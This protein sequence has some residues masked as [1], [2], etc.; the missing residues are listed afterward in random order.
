[1]FGNNPEIKNIA[2]VVIAFVI[3][4]IVAS[5]GDKT[6]EGELI[7]INA[8]EEWNFA[9]EDGGKTYAAVPE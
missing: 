7:D 8:V 2:L 4:T 6:T 5:C 9:D 3:T 1:M